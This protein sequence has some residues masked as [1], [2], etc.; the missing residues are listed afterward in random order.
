MSS[1]TTCTLCQREDCMW[2]N[3]GSGKCQ[4]MI[5]TQGRE[6]RNVQGDVKMILKQLEEK[7]VELISGF[8]TT[9]PQLI[10]WWSKMEDT[11]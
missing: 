4:Q 2:F 9:D 8:Y 10:H 3:E 11:R 5:I 1:G 6:Q 7:T